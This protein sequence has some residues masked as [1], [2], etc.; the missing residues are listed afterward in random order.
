M[1]TRRSLA[2]AFLDRYAALALSIVASMVLARLLTPAEVGVYSVAMAL[3]ALAATVRDMGAGQYLVRE[4]D[5]TPERI[6]AVWT[7]QLGIGVALAVLV[8]A[9][10]VPAAAFY[11]EPVM[12]DILWLLALNYLVNPFG[13]ITYAWLIREMRYDSIAVMRF[14]SA[15]ASTVVSVVLAWRGHGAISLAWGSLCGT[16]AN[17]AIS[18]CYRPG[19]YP[20]LPGAQ[21]IGR[22]LSFGGRLTVASLMRT[23]ATGAPEF[24]LGRLQGLAAAGFYSRSQ[25]LVAMFDR[26]VS[27]AVGNVAM[28]LFSKEARANHDSRPSFLRAIAYVTALSWPFAVSLCLLAHPATRVLYGAQWDASVPLTRWL[29]AGMAFMSLV[30]L[31]TAVLVGTGDMNRLMKATAVLAVA[32]IAAAATGASLGLWQIGATLFAGSVV[33]GTA[34]LATACRVLDVRAA[35]LWQAL[36]PS[37]VVAICT[38][39]GAAVSPLWFGATPDRSILPLAVGAAGALFGLLAGLRVSRHPLTAEIARL[40]PLL[41]RWLGAR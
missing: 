41:G 27:D 14:G 32:A 29:A 20:W 5:L 1:S 30:P 34:F 11:R 9:A 4:K 8:F 17:A 36:R 26:L 31:S 15:L 6:R 37:A 12:R 3:L 24:L 19:G 33:G 35:A 16:V 18:M 23:L 13:S 25:G 40:S 39:A 38:G 2:Y 7:V 22:V 21:G 28:A 10:S